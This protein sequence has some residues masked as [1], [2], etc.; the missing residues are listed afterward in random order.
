M[1]TVVQLRAEAKALGAKRY[2]KLRKAELEALVA[3]YRAKGSG[4]VESLRKTIPDAPDDNDASRPKADALYLWRT[5]LKEQGYMAGGKKIP[6]KGSAEHAKLK[7]IYYERMSR[8]ESAAPVPTRTAPV[9]EEAEE[10]VGEHFEGT[11][12]EYMAETVPKKTEPIKVAKNVKPVFHLGTKFTTKRE[13]MK[14]LDIRELLGQGQFGE[15]YLVCNPTCT[16]VLK[17]V[18]DDSDA[19]NTYDEEVHFAVD[20]ST[21]RYGPKVY[22]YWT[23]DGEFDGG[24]VKLGFIL[25]DKYDITLAAYRT[26]IGGDIPEELE[27]RIED[28]V[29]RMHSKGVMHGDLHAKNVML[30]VDKGKKVKDVTLID[31]GYAMRMLA[32]PD[33]LEARFE[34]RFDYPLVGTADAI[35]KFRD[36]DMQRWRKPMKASPPPPPSQASILDEVANV[37]D[38]AA[39]WLDEWSPWPSPAGM[40]KV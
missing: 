7:R 12:E 1:P 18:I 20:A 40:K 6:N 11:L 15:A 32:P 5:V 29:H 17:V 33:D 38:Q 37:I 13:C 30:K 23:C 9:E 36:D 39:A 2:S 3:Q 10:L 24:P 8:K 21:D 34:A 19:W 26:A 22:D 35:A 14:G 28:L 27:M 25:M 31:Y 16:S 4:K